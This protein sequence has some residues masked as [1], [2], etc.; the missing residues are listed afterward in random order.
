MDGGPSSRRVQSTILRLTRNT[1]AP[2]G[3]RPAVVGL[4]GGIWSTRGWRDCHSH[5]T[6]KGGCREVCGL[7]DTPGERS[8]RAGLSKSVLPVPV[9][10][11]HLRA[12]ET[13]HDL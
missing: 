2:G 4:T 3:R 6:C 5:A 1:H 7:T 9:S 11:T 10:Y 8:T 12:H 13:R